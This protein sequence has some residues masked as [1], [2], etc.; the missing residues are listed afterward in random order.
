MNAGD[1]GPLHA[2][3]DAKLAGIAE[4]SPSPGPGSTEEE[5]PRVNQAVRDS[6]C[7]PADAGFYLPPSPATIRSI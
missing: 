2:P 7:L 3:I 6:G 5:R 1:N 4:G